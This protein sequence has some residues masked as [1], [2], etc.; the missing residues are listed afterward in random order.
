MLGHKDVGLRAEDVRRISEAHAARAAKAKEDAGRATSMMCTCGGTLHEDAGVARRARE[1]A[2]KVV[3]RPRHRKKR[4]LKKRL[5]AWEAKVRLVAGVSRSMMLPGYICGTCGQR[6][7]FYSA[8]GRN[9]F[10]VEP[11][12]LGAAPVFFR[13]PS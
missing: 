10:K 7:G 6:S 5:R 8:I 9:L 1:L 13:E 3:L 2:E 12:P 11:L 4:I